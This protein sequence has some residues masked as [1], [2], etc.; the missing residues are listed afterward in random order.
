M[1]L[2]FWFNSFLCTVLF[3]LESCVSTRLHTYTPR[4]RGARLAGEGHRGI[5]P[6]LCP[7]KNVCTSFSLVIIVQSRLA[8]PPLFVFSTHARSRARGTGGFLHRVIV[9]VHHLAGH[10]GLWEED[11]FRERRHERF[12]R[13]RQQ[14]VPPFAG[15]AHFHLGYVDACRIASTLLHLFGRELVLPGRVQAVQQLHP[16]ADGLRVERAD[17]PALKIAIIRVHALALGVAHTRNDSNLR[18]AAKGLENLL[19]IARSKVLAEGSFRGKVVADGRLAAAAAVVGDTVVFGGPGQVRAHCGV[20]AVRARAH[21]LVLDLHEGQG[22]GGIAYLE[23][24]L[25]LRGSD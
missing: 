15:K 9:G 8:S 23:A 1:C 18:R 25:A 22:E 19:E 6:G 3:I 17:S 4:I 13:L 20:A 14:L 11:L 2:V 24:D 12:R 7:Q 21:R 5:A 16:R 10:R